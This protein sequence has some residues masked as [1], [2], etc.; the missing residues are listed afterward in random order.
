MTIEWSNILR[1]HR[2]K[3]GISMTVEWS[4]I[5]KTHQR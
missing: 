5:L 3:Q 4:N 1:T 2:D